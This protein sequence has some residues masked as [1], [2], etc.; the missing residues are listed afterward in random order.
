[1]RLA[2][3]A[4]LCIFVL[5]SCGGPAPS[6][7]LGRTVDTLSVYRVSVE[8]ESSFSG[9]GLES[10]TNLTAAFKVR[11]SP[12]PNAE[13]EVLYL[14]ASVEDAD[15]NPVALSLGRL[16]GKQATVELRPPGNVEDISGDEELLEAAVP[17]LSMRGIIASLFPPLPGESMREQDNWTG[18][19]PAPFPSWT[20][21]TRRARPARSK[22][23]NSASVPDPSRRRPRPVPSPEKER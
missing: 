20:P 11:P 9:S 8:A 23:T 3:P 12:G 4:L 2:L 6:L 7:D 1:M 13:V 14:A 21:P 19:I 10:E 17:L 22:A 16:A 18:D 5:A 15:G